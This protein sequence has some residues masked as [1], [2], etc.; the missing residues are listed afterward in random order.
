MLL[1]L[2]P[3]PAE[4]GGQQPSWDEGHTLFL[5][6]EMAVERLNCDPRILPGY[7]VVLAKSDSGCNI[8]SKATLSVIRDTLYSEERIVGMV[9]PGCSGSA[10]TIGPLTGREQISLINV[11]VAGS[12]LLADRDVYP[13]SFGTLDSTEVFVE[14]LLRLIENMQWSHVSALYDESRLYYYSTL[15]YMEQRIHNSTESFLRSLNYSS[16]AVY[17]TH[18]PLNI[19]KNKHRVILLFVGPDFLSKI[20]CLAL[21]NDMVYPVYQFVIVSRTAEEI[22]PVSFVYE[23][24]NIVCNQMDIM[25][26][27]NKAIV[28][29]YQLRPINETALTDSGFSYQEFDQLYREKVA[30]FMAPGITIEPSFW[31]PSFFDAVWSLGLAL[32]NSMDVVNLS[33][34]QFQHPED[35]AIIR[36][37][38]LNLSYD[39]ISG[40][41][42][43][44]RD[45][46]YVKRNVAIYQ[47]NSTGSMENIGYYNRRTNTINLTRGDLVTGNFNQSTVILTAPVVLAYPVL[48]ITAVGFVMVL[49]LQILTIHYRKLKS[50]KATSFKLSQLA[51]VGCYIQVLGSVVNVCVDIYTDKI[52][53]KTNCILWHLLNVAAAIGTTL[54][55][56]TV[57]ARTWRLYR[58]FEHF[59]NPGKLMSEKAL[60]SGVLVFVAINIIICMLWIKVD[61]FLECVDKHD[62]VYED[63]VERN[64]VVNIKIVQVVIHTCTQNYFVVWCVLLM[65]INM[66]FMAAAVVLAFL[67]RHIPYRDFKTRGI[68]ALTY[69]LTGILGL[70]F[71]VYTILLTQQ[72]YWVILSRFLVV[73]VL[74]NLYVYLSCFLLFLPPLYPL[75]KLKLSR[76]AVGVADIVKR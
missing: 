31:A 24:S 68:M 44:N 5:T 22:T 20:L 25:K 29:H 48:I 36:D 47:I 21:K 75:L 59:Q 32:N 49:V 64:E 11:H 33:S 14:T 57:C 53:P 73:S 13:N 58:I 28:I 17:T 62:M 60:I 38:L 50:I 67:T 54:I 35:S 76:W 8:K 66:V 55:F 42:S 71:S 30:D 51:Y 27:I 1:S 9:G 6:E 72:S 41:I 2:L 19:L 26:I 3:Y 4:E 7:N 45:T 18:I 43:F 34:Y 56:G 46:G 65:L 70:G 15:Q 74:L 61:P 12:R 52:T 63:I 23:R 10:S 69:V 39:G 16:S 40:R 37:R